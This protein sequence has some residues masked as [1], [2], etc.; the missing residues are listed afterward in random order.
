MILPLYS[1]KKHYSS[2]LEDV[3]LT[4][5]KS[6]TYIGHKVGKEKCGFPNWL[7]SDCWRVLYQKH[8]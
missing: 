6:W 2:F 7:V 5:I 3:T 8:P 4:F 1:I